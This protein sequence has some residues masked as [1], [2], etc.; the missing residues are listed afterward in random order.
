MTRLRDEVT[1]LLTRIIT[2]LILLPLVIAA[3]WYLPPSY[4]SAVVSL[5]I[6]LGA[7][8]WSGFMPGLSIL[9][10]LCF[11]LLIAMGIY[12][13]SHVPPVWVLWLGCFA[14]GWI[15][16]ATIA[17]QKEKQPLG[18]QAPI[19][20]LILGFFV[21][22]PCWVALT[23]IRCITSGHYGSQLV[24]YVLVIIWATDIG[25]YFTGKAFG[26]KH[27]ISRVSPKKTWAGL[28]G[29]LASAIFVTFIGTFL[30][31]F[32]FK[33][34]LIMLLVG[35]LTAV[36]S[37][38]G[39]LGVSLLKRLSKIKDSGSIFPGHGGVLDR[40]DSV[41]AATVIFV[42]SLPMVGF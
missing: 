4:F 6:L 14:W 27:L 10:R 40:M 15:S 36:F 37:V 1:L 3:I 25:A 16:I 38:F 22:L 28:Y 39:D 34:Q 24:L 12:G 18:L 30:F 13:V 29:G 20:R 7:W 42:L 21:L 26:Q 32:T 35:L 9:K 19:S 11:V 5:F 2:A 41:A 31:A 33:S 23:N 17:Y 8:E